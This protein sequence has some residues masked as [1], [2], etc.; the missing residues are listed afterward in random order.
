MRAIDV[1]AIVVFWAF[2]SFVSAIGRELDPRIPNVSRTVVSAVVGATYVEY[3]VWALLTVPIWWLASRYS[4]ERGRRIER[5]VA[6]AT[7]GFVVAIGMDVFLRHIR[8]GFLPPIARFR[9]R[10]VA[11]AVIGGLGFLDD[12]MVYFAVLGS[13]IARDY[14]LRYRA[15]LQETIQLQTQ[16]TQARLDALRGQLNPHFL[17][18]TLNSVS[19]LLERDPRGARRMIA[20]L[21]ELLRYT[22]EESTEQEVPLHR[23]LDVLGEYIDLMQI[24]FQDKLD[25]R[26]EVP[27]DTRSAYV[28][29]LLLQPIVENALKHGVAQQTGVGRIVIRAASDGADLVLSVTDNG[30]GPD[31]GGGSDGVGLTNT[32]ARLKQLYGDRYGVTLAAA[33]G[34]QG[35]AE[36]R[37][38]LP[39]HRQPIAVPGAAQS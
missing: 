21:S 31:V 26:I 11:P 27:D 37:I 16:L 10:R 39:F 22:L 6:F 12:L 13:G 5:I 33:N 8:D 9:V 28:P 35:G 4:V 25:V 23:E 19:A 1:S 14:F 29:N 20:R 3:A 32:N 15:R 36:A 17:F 18:N 30:P 24:R 38:V 2:L 7:L 34:A